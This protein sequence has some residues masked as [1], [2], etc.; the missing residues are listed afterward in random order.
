MKRNTELYQ[1]IRGEID[2]IITS[3]GDKRQKLQAICDLLHSRLEHFDW[4]GFYLVNEKNQELVLGPFT[5]KAT[6]HVRIPFGRG[7]C[8]QVVEKEK[9]LVIRD[10][11]AETNYLSCS[12]D[13]KSEIVV[14]IFEAEKIVGELDIDSHLISPFIQ[15]D[16]DLCEYIC[17]SIPGLIHDNLIASFE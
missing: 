12:P 9:T 14:P 16:I 17:K 11:S 13:V 3:S 5:G 8:G 7:I 4:V 15:D 1:K 6:E 2:R 10:V